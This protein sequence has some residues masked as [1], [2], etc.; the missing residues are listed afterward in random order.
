MKLGPAALAASLALFHDAGLASEANDY[1]WFRGTSGWC[2]DVQ[3]ERL[4]IPFEI[5][6]ES[7]R[8]QSI[9]FTELVDGNE[10]PNNFLFTH[11]RSSGYAELAEADDRFSFVES[12][13]IPGAIAKKYLVADRDVL[14]VELENGVVV[15]LV[16]TDVNE[17][18]DIAI[19][20]SSSW[21]RL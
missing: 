15:A 2:V 12:F 3:Q 19:L 9:R 8:P 7:I 14:E 20:F 13:D 10:V 21:E 18:L 1:R 11:D 4:C 16:G 5:E 17:L 6:V